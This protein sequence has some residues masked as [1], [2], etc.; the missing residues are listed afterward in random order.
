MFMALQGKRVLVGVGGGIAA[1]KAVELVRELGRRG[2]E[3]R[4]A[5]TEAAT[6]FVGPVTF[7]GIT[8]RAAVTDLWD[9]SYAGEVH[10]ELADWAELIVVAPATANLLTRAA[11]GFADDVVLATL[12]C[13]DRPVLLAPA[14][15]ERMWRAA[16]TQ[17]AVDLLRSRGTAFVG[18]VEGALASGAVG[19]GRMAEPS[20]IAGAVEQQ[21]AHG[22][23]LQGRT[24][25]VSAGPT[26]EDLDPVRYIGNR[27]SGRMGYAVAAAAQARGANVV[28]VTGP[29]AIEPPAGIEVVRVRSAEQMRD[30][31]LPRA[32]NV[33]A[34]VMTAA[35][36]DYRP[37]EAA[38]NKLKKSD[39]ALTIELIANP[40]ILAE[41]G[42]TR[43]GARPLL[44]GF[45]M[46][47]DDVV[48]YARKKLTG[49]RVDLMVANAAAV[50][51]RDDT[52]ATL[53][54]A[55]GDEALGATTKRE[56]AERILDRIVAKLAT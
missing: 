42:R 16:A 56:L 28:L 43:E 26:H 50:F 10:V 23:D 31:I 34:I 33:D 51:G 54:S 6:R 14:M 5:M 38:A 12:A 36:A 47:T 40:D 13:A 3:V 37:K 20:E 21:L 46:E 1:Y 19:M 17:H 48:G 44:V 25:L 49:K 24:M 35:V 32:K 41:L 29:T 4:V 7:S 22:R 18:P 15:H 2:A 53:V 52:D 11:H 8:G 30:A 39:A 9:A 27:S 55:D 45:A